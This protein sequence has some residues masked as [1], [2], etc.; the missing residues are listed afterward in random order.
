MTVS[1]EDGG[2]QNVFAREP[3]M[4]VDKTYVEKYGFETHAERAEKAN[5]RA[6]MIGLVFGLFSYAITGNFYFGL[7]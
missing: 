1:T 7:A 2:R 4:Y 3:Q 6:A 5:G